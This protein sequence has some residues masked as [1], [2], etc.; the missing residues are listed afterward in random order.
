[1]GRVKSVAM[2][3][4]L[5]LMALA[6]WAI[7]AQPVYQPQQAPQATDQQQPPPPAQQQQ[8]PAAADPGARTPCPRP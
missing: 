3:G 5:P 1:M 2:V 7:Q 8:P 4:L 6:P